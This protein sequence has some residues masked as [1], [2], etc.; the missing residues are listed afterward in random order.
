MGWT[1]FKINTTATTDQVLRREFTQDSKGGTRP[2]WDV[3]ESATVGAQWYGIMC[4]TDYDTSTPD[5]S[6]AERKT[7]YGMICLTERKKIKGSDMT[8]FYYKDMDESCGPYAYAM[9]LRMLAKLEELAPAPVGFAAK[10]R[11]GVRMHHERKAAK[12]KARRENKQRL[13]DFIRGHVQFIHVG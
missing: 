4:R 8:E 2:A 1:S 5:G 12:A 13:Q 3:L 9:P 11:E 7:Y 10:W 6:I